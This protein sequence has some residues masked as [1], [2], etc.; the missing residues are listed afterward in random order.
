MSELKKCPFCGSEDV[1]AI[2]DYGFHWVCCHHC[3]VSGTGSK[4]W[5]VAR[6]RWNTRPLEDALQAR[7]DELEGKVQTQARWMETFWR[8]IIEPSNT[9][10]PP[11]QARIAEL[12]QAIGLLTT[13]KGDMEIR[14]DDPLGM[15]QE[16]ERYVTERIATFIDRLK[17]RNK[18]VAEL[19]RSNLE[20]YRRIATL[21]SQLRRIPVSER[22]PEVNGRYLVYSDY[23]KESEVGEWSVI[24]K[25]WDLAGENYYDA[26]DFDYWMPLPNPP[27]LPTPEVSE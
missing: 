2:G 18:R 22:L 1:E 11:L 12:Y 15:A 9:P 7:I 25:N 23:L 19:L 16:V 14:G 27:E 24:T 10:M 20:Q 17:N 26:D 21:E 8:G 5:D 13:L 4:D 6:S 3:H